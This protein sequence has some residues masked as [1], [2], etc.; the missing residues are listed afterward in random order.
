MKRLTRRTT[1]ATAGM[2]LLAGCLDTLG[3]R[4]ESGDDS[5]TSAGDE[6]Y[7]DPVES[8][9]NPHGGVPTTERNLPL[10]D[11]LSEMDQWTEQGAPK[12]AIPVIDDPEFMDA[13][14]GDA[15]LD[16]GDPIIGMVHDGEPRA[17]PQNILV[18]H[19]IVN[20][21][22]GG[23]AISVTYCPLTGTA[24][25]FARGNTT[26]G[27]SGLLLN[28][29]LIMYDRASD[30]YW[31]QMLAVGLAGEHVGAELVEFNVVWTDWEDW[32]T[33]YPETDVLTE[34]TGYARDYQRDPYG[35]FNPI[36]GYYEGESLMFPQYSDGAEYDF[37]PKEVFIGARTEEGAVAVS[38]DTLAE[39]GIMEGTLG[40]TQYV[41][42][43]DGTLHT[44]WCYRNPD[45]YDIRADNGRVLVDGDP[46]EPDSLPIDPVVRYDAMWFAWEGYYPETEVWQ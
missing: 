17:Y 2:A 43:Y 3:G 11:E 35:S 34:E 13:A 31:P 37:H 39:Q 8:V 24:Q 18:W 20:D 14:D 21:V 38:K 6:E 1:L 10:P 33:N 19:E 30:T 5:S 25:A 32:R 9:D 36:G 40:G 27:V 15:H 42:V 23:D 4:G 44:G 41:M 16:P 29:N 46:H 7:P 28:S 12:D 22:I 45:A 26:F